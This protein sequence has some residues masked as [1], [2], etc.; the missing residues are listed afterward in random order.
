MG[1][2]K[3]YGD[4]WDR[5]GV[6]WSPRSAGIELNGRRRRTKAEKI[7]FRHQIGIYALFDRDRKIVYVGQT[8]RGDRAS[9]FG[10][11]RRHR[12]GRL[13]DRWTH[14]SWFGLKGV[15]EDG[16]LEDFHEQTVGKEVV[17]DELE[18]ILIHLVEP[19]LNRQGA[20]WA[21]AVEFVQWDDKDPRVM[22]GE[23]ID[24]ED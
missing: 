21:G 17:L 15:L 13:R 19:P 6:N 10:R 4:F 3:C 24:D 8:G 23:G 22:S 9:L 18:A 7:N 16:E 12:F 2:I 14:F 5:E 11:L 1:A 20:K